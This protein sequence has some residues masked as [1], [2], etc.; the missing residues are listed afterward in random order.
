MGEIAEWMYN[1]ALKQEAEINHENAEVKWAIDN[2]NM[3]YN[4]GV[5]KWETKDGN[6]ININDMTDKHIMNTID[7]LKRK[8]QKPFVLEWIKILMFELE[9]R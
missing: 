8:E 1:E 4:R 2:I 7:F 9:Q 3:E 5:L 6:K